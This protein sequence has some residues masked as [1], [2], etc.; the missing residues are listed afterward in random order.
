MKKRFCYRP[1]NS[2][3]FDPDGRARIC[4]WTDVKVGNV[5]EE[6]IEE[7]W[8]GEKAKLF[9]ESFEDDS[10]RYCRVESCPFLENDS[11]PRVTEEEYHK[12]S[13][14]PFLPTDVTIANDRTCNHSCPSC[15]H[16]ICI[17]T[18]E[19]KERFAKESKKIVPLLNQTKS[20]DA[21]G[22]GDVLSSP[23]MLDMLS[24]VHPENKACKISLETNG[25][26][27]DEVHWKKI[28]HFG[29]Y[30]LSVTVTPNSFVETTYRYLN[31]GHND[32]DKL[33]ANL[34]YI[35]SLRKCGIVNYFAISIVV[36]E[37]N[38]FELPSFIERCINDFE[39][40]KVVVKPLYNWFN[41]GDD[42]YWFKDVANPLHPYHKE[43]LEIMN[44]PI[45]NHEKVFLWG[46]KNLHETAKHPAYRYEDLLK[47]VAKIIDTP[48]IG[49]RINKFL[50]EQKKR[51]IIVYGETM[52]T[53]SVVKLLKGL[54]D[55]KC[56]MALAP[57]R[58]EIAG[59]KVKPFC[60]DDIDA[61]DCV[62][63]LNTD[64]IKQI[65]RDF[66]F[67]GYE[68]CLYTLDEFISHV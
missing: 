7:I 10:F 19:D 27:F 5:C 15:R 37:R 43:W 23:M 26:L 16:E 28:E 11:L 20:F 67:N 17:P 60:T 52:I 32:Y 4:A 56:I 29:D 68:D 48:D 51:R 34:Y 54:T 14:L 55:I 53:A 57:C 31:G 24:Q 65:R 33:I 62:V 38:V 49:E 58:K 30:H 1:Y 59:V 46:A 40:D 12:L 3:H 39:V 42:S 8:H 47:A 21:N 41:M 13:K 35:K 45:M 64:K 18:P 2:I 63:V 61:E 36:Q 25:A 22:E 44:Q 66:D 6:T 50:A 9:R